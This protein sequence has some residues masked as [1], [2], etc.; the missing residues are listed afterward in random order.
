[1]GKPASKLLGIRFSRLLVVAQLPNSRG[2][3]RWLCRCDCGNELSTPPGPLRSGRTKSCG[4]M[5]KAI[6][7]TSNL[8]H[9]QA[10]TRVHNIWRGMLK[11]CLNH[12][13]YAGRGIKVCERW[14]TF[15]NFLADMGQPPDGY[16]IERNDN[17]LDYEPGNCEWIPQ[18]KQTRN[19]SRTKRISING[20]SLSLAEWCERLGARY[21]LVYDR[22]QVLGWEPSRALTEPSHA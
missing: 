6:L 22:I 15:E 7:A 5:R 11:R 20:E 3:T 10:E 19:T 13:R 9:G 17:N 16:S 14:K 2:C 1:M 21:R 8:M 4:C 12:P 18:W